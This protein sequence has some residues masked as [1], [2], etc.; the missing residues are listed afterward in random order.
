MSACSSADRPGDRGRV[1]GDDFWVESEINNFFVL[2][3]FVCGWLIVLPRT[4]VKYN[5]NNNGKSNCAFILVLL[6]CFYYM[7]CIWY[8]VCYYRRKFYRRN[9]DY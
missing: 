8:C 4:H 5:V 3:N 9:G 7:V 6:P 1:P 2:I